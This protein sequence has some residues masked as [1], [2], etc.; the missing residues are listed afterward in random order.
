MNALTLPA[1]DLR[2]RPLRTALTALGI[3]AAVSSYLTL[4]SLSQG[5]ERGWIASLE[6]RGVHMLALS[7]DTVEVMASSLPEALGPQIAAE[8]GVV[9]ASGEMANLIRL[10]L[11]GAGTLHVTVRGWPPDSFKWRSLPLGDGR[12]PGPDEPRAIVLGV[13]LAGLLRLG[14]GDA[15]ALRGEPFVVTGIAAPGGVWNDRALFLPLAAM[16]DLFDRPGQVT[17][18]SLQVARPQDAAF[19]ADL[20]SRLEERFERLAF[21]ESAEIAGQNDVVRTF[22]AFS[23]AV[24]WVAMGMALLIVLNTLLM[25]VTERT[26]EIGILAAVGWGPGRVLGTV[27]VQGLL[28]TA[29]GAAAGVALGAF[30]LG[31]VLR[32]PT[33]GGLV[34]PGLRPEVV[35]E[36]LIAAL[37]VGA[38]GGLYPAWRAA[39]ARP[40]ASLRHG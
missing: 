16:Q 38:V 30:S 2:R 18:F 37:L 13:T 17:E 27:V 35:A 15:Y 11:P 33:L 10:E 23:G 5:L 34:E 22:R 29:V 26:R 24:S 4:V 12:P 14:V 25:S 21:L 31:V 36:T 1:A 19:V 7:R 40:A 32:H 9:Q 3:A 20:T 39:R 8:E 28:L 6:G